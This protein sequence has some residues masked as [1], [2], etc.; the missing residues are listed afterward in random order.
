MHSQSHALYFQHIRDQECPIDYDQVL[1]ATTLRYRCSSSLL[2]QQTA[3]NELHDD[4][5]KVRSTNA[6]DKE[7]DNEEE[8]GFYVDS[9]DED[10]YSGIKNNK[11][12]EQQ[13]QNEAWSLVEV[14]PF[15][16][17]GRSAHNGNKEMH[18]F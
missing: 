16:V 13:P 11:Q 10:D 15:A 1:R 14:A 12:K 8:Y 3:N 9:E 7:S 17:S 2:Q 5:Y 6:G 18:I 4:F